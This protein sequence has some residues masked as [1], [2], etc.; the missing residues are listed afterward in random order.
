MDIK[1][2]SVQAYDSVN[3]EWNNCNKVQRTKRVKYKKK[4]NKKKQTNNN[5]EQQYIRVYRNPV[6][7]AYSVGTQR[8]VLRTAINGDRNNNNNNEAH[9]LCTLHNAY[10]HINK[11]TFLTFVLLC[12]RKRRCMCARIEITTE[13]LFDQLRKFI[14]CDREKY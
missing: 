11:E 1:K 4:K 6:N 8:R 7:S 14:F 12:V 9:G 2:N 3:C 13:S 10:I 5:N